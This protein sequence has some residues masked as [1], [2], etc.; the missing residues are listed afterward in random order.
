MP[1]V[2]RVTSRPTKFSCKRYVKGFSLWSDKKGG[3]NLKVKLFYV[4]CLMCTYMHFID[5]V[6]LPFETKS[7]A[8]WHHKIIV[9]SLCHEIIDVIL[10][11]SLS[12]SR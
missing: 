5:V 3:R 7:K 1:V 9:L 2:I 10:I 11:G 6:I 8:K 12:Y 4:S